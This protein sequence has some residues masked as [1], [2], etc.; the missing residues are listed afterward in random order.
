MK[1]HLPLP[2]MCQCLLPSSMVRAQHYKTDSDGLCH[3]LVKPLPQAGGK[4]FV[5]RKKFTTGGWE[6]ESKNLK[7]E[8]LLGSGQFGGTCIRVGVIEII[9]RAWWQ[10]CGHPALEIVRVIR[11]VGVV[12][13]SLATLS[14]FSIDS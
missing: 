10:A 14:A 12:S 4:E 6:I 11:V 13:A 2:D 7:R 9:S 5:D 3:H 1:K 8:Q